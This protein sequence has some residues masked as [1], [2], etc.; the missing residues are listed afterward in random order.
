MLADVV[1]LGIAL[2]ELAKT[3]EKEPSFKALGVTLENTRLS[4]DDIEY[5]GQIVSR[6]VPFKV[7]YVFHQG[8]PVVWLMRKEVPYECTKF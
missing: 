3:M 4:R 8:V 6:E 2:G 1:K 7:G 5:L